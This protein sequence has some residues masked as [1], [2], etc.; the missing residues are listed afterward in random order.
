M[1]NF[2]KL[3]EK[4]EGEDYLYHTTF[5]DTLSGILK[6]GL[7]P[8][9]DSPEQ[10]EEMERADELGM[11]VDEFRMYSNGSPM[12]KARRW[13]EE[14][15]GDVQ[16]FRDDVSELPP[17][18]GS[19]FFWTQENKAVGVA[20]QM[21]VEGFVVVVDPEKIPC[22]CAVANNDEADG[23]WTYFY[24]VAKE[25]GPVDRDREDMLANTFWDSAEWYDGE[26]GASLEVWCDCEIPKSAIVKVLDDDGEL[27]LDLEEPDEIQQI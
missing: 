6:E 21:D 17:H 19:V 16:R 27:M 4:S 15:L 20:Y 3:N 18:E 11:D 12:V 8:D 22:R 1:V 25:Q 2:E 5:K 10:K 26:K 23:V 13:M 24:N 14:L 7:V 9:K